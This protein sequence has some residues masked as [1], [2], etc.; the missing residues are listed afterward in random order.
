MIPF[1]LFAQEKQ[2]ELITE[3]IEN[4]IVLHGKNNLDETITFIV[5]ITS[6]GYGLKKLH[7]V[8]KR[9][10]ANAEVE[11]IK[12]H[13]RPNRSCSYSATYKYTTSKTRTVNV[14]ENKTSSET[15]SVRVVN[16]Q[17]INTPLNAA[18]ISNKGIVVYSKDGCGRCEYVTNYLKLYEIPFTDRNITNDR[19]AS[20]EMSKLLF[21]EGFEGGTF[22]TP[23]VTIDGEVFYNI[24]N[25]KEFVEK[26]R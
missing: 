15:H 21:E 24:P 19:S 5:E 14:T 17:E 2:A 22:K 25:I 18:P 6:V 3:E 8:S 11:L 13:S 4:G 16:E 20:D 10:P 23:V 7:T 26:F 1:F 12:M 9:I